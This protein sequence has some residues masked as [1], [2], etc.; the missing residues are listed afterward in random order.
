LLFASLEPQ[1][2]STAGQDVVMVESGLGEK[3]AV[4]GWDSGKKVAYLG[5]EAQQ[6]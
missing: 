1:H 3:T 6:G 4:E 2:D 5:A